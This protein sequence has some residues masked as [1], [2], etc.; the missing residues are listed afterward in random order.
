MSSAAGLATVPCPR[1]DGTPGS[2]DRDGAS[3]PAERLGV[4]ARDDAARQLERL[5]RRID[6]CQ[7]RSSQAAEHRIRD[8]FHW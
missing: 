8:K 4:R 1:S 5:V 3:R 7:L 6:V 2:E